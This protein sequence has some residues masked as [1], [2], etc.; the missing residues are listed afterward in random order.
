[1]VS[2]VVVQLLQW[3]VFLQLYLSFQHG[4][5]INVVFSHHFIVVCISMLFCTHIYF[6]KVEQTEPGLNEITL[7]TSLL[8]PGV[9]Q[10]VD[11][12]WCCWS[13]VRLLLVLYFYSSAQKQ[14]FPKIGWSMPPLLLLPLKVHALHSTCSTHSAHSTYLLKTCTAAAT[15]DPIQFLSATDDSADGVLDVS[16]SDATPL[17]VLLSPAAAPFGSIPTQNAGSATN[18]VDAAMRGIYHTVLSCYNI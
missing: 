14:Q 8:L 12:Q 6:L 3:L 15:F 4:Q 17:S 7:G 11:A 5:V 13:E 1:V 2:D 10:Y 18:D 9:H 16:A